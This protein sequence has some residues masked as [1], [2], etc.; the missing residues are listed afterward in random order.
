M[1]NV[2]K[3]NDVPKNPNKGSSDENSGFDSKSLDVEKA[4]TYDS[5]LEKKLIQ[6]ELTS[7]EK[8]DRNLFKNQFNENSDY[9]DLDENSFPIA[10]DSSFPSN[11]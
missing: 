9:L 3:N 7:K 10:K 11:I 8:Q 1:E 4:N 2:K 5:P 6:S